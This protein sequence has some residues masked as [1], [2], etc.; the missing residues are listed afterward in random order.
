MSYRDN[1]WRTATILMTSGLGL[2]GSACASDSSDEVTDGATSNIVSGTAAPNYPEAA[3]IDLSD[4]NGRYACSG[5][6]I[7]PKVVLTAGHCVLVGSTWTVHVGK[8]TRTTESSRAMDRLDGTDG[9]QDLTMH[10]VG[11]IF[12]DEP[13]VL[14]SY[15]D[16]ATEPL[17]DGS[18]VIV[19]GRMLNGNTTSQF[20]ARRV[21]VESGTS[22]HASEL[23]GDV[24][25]NDYLVPQVVTEHGD[26]GG[27]VFAAGTHEIVG[28]VRAAGTS[29]E[30][31]SR[32]DLARDFITQQV[33]AHGG[34]AR[35][36]PGGA[37]A[38]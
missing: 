9:H 20:W 17:P 21:S 7:A 24:A 6:L 27:P 25:P 11:L 18:A 15:P 35:V 10:D 36:S 33:Q 37:T 28:L 26:S 34:F 22:D 30:V 32:V 16:L 31:F 4:A 38:H 23:L 1:V 12:F 3:T 29:E 14:E 2:M 5:V 19:T 8:E 13:I